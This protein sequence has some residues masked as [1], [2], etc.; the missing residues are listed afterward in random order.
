MRLQI[1]KNQ[2]T[3]QRENDGTKVEKLKNLNQYV[4]FKKTISYS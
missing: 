1:P 2:K 3:S 4:F